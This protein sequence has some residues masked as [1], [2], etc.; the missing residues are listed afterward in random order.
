LDIDAK[1]MNSYVRGHWGIEN[2]LHW[3][4]DVI[5]NEDKCR[6]RKENSPE[7]FSIIR[8][9]ALNLLKNNTSTKLS[10]NKKR[11]KAILNEDYLLTL[12]TF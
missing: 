6:I 1:E 10:I 12:F 9:I 8:R 2:S 4:P 3:V 11:L 5:F 7:N